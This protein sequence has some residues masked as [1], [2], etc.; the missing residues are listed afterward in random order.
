MTGVC[1]HLLE[2]PVESLSLLSGVTGHGGKKEQEK[3]QGFR[4]GS[5]V[6]G[7]S[8]GTKGRELMDTLEAQ[9]SFTE[10]KGEGIAAG[11]AGQ[12]VRPARPTTWG[13]KHSC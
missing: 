3:K 5:E 10:E 11:F 4:Q 12:V 13:A 2:N 1:Q 8:W 6:T 9:C 7:C